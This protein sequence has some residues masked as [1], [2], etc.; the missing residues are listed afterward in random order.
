VARKIKAL[1]VEC[2]FQIRLSKP[3]NGFKIPTFYTPNLLIFGLLT[4]ENIDF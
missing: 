3:Q 2:F 1:E 4:L